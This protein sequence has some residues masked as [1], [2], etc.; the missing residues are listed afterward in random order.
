[1]KFPLGARD[2]EVFHEIKWVLQGPLYNEP[3]KGNPKK[4]TNIG[5]P[6]IHK[7]QIYEMQAECK[8]IIN[9]LF[10]R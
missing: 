4:E 1:M 2:S 5:L 8:Y 6:S 3:N 10:Q 7:N 9:P